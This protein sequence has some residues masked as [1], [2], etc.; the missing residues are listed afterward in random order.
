MAF[1]KSGNLPMVHG[2]TTTHFKLEQSV[3]LLRGSSDEFQLVKGQPKVSMSNW[4]PLLIAIAFKKV[5]I[6][7]YF[8][9]DKQIA[10]SW[11]G[12][13]PDGTQDH[14]FA[15]KLAIINQDLPML[16]ELWAGAQYQAWDHV[17]FQWLLK[18]LILEHHWAKGFTAVMN[19]SG[20]DSAWK[21]TESILGSLSSSDL[22][23]TLRNDVFQHSITAPNPEIQ[24]AVDEALSQKALS[25]FAIHLL[26]TNETFRPAA[27]V[28]TFIEKHLESLNH[29]SYLKY[30]STQIAEELKAGMAKFEALGDQ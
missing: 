19:G 14:T 21:T 3:I 7:R 18:Q 29:N 8:L 1:V 4:N 25:I 24:K 2:L 13:A 15:L 30:H 20:K 22:L 5:E 26:L 12:R 27:D 6:V 28:K 9:A 16:V 11:A 17:H 10:L 23:S